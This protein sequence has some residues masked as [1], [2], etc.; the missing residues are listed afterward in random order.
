MM[1]YLGLG[2]NLGDRF[3]SLSRAVDSLRGEP[4]FKHLAVSPV[5]ETMPADMPGQPSFLNAA[6]FF[7]TCLDPYGVLTVCGEIEISLGRVRTVIGGPR[8]IDID[9]ELYG[10][11]VIKSETLIIP[12]PRLHLRDFVLQPLIDLQP[13]LIHP[14]LNTP[15]TK[16]LCEL[17]TR[18]IIERHPLTL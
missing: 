17:E 8:T 6:V 18:Y 9:I 4:G 16:I 2:S 13:D 1:V 10:D 15:L 3:A 7:E 14:A 5:Y 11:R 12:H